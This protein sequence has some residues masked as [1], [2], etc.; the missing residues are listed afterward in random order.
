MTGDYWTYS[1]VQ[2][3]A[4]RLRSYSPARGPAWFGTPPEDSGA[5][6]YVGDVPEALRA[7]FGSAQPV[8]RLDNGLR[9]NNLVQGAPIWLRQDRTQ[10]WSEIWPRI[11]RP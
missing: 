11:R 9:V 1:G 10:P 4:P 3:F 5:V 6:L 7:A 2:H 8:G